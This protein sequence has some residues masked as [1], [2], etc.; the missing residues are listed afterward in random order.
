MRI[1]HTGD[2]HIGINRWGIDRSEEVFRSIDFIV[3]T[4][5]EED[6][7]VILI[8]GDLFDHRTPKGENLQRA[9]RILQ[10]LGESERKVIVVTGNHDWNDLEASLNMF[11]PLS[12]VYFLTQIGVMSFETKKGETLRLGVLPYFWERDFMFM[13]GE[14]VRRENLGE[15]LRGGLD[16]INRGFLPDTVNILLAHTFI[17]GAVLGSAMRLSF[18]SNFALPPSW[19]PDRAHYVA[20]GHA[21]KPQKIQN[22]PVPAYYSGSI[23]RIDFSELDDK[24][25]FNIIDVKPDRPAVIEQ[26][27]IPC[28]ELMELEIKLSQLESK[29]IL[30]KDFDGYIKVKLVVDVTDKNPISRVKQLIPNCIEVETVYPAQSTGSVS[31][32]DLTS[33][34]S[35]LFHQYLI[36]KDGR[37]DDEVIKLFEELYR[38]VSSD[39]NPEH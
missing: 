39:E 26:R 27:E 1:L 15:R 33:E 2:W 12:N 19:L 16:K 30:V 14:T 3:K 6:I 32:V 17:E 24:K 28:R 36:L 4:V 20:L 38:E 23:I 9:T 37:V 11:S 13:G 35:K 10:K 31:S 21:H 34:P 18:S 5:E 25:S 22:S 8:A 29:A 7:D